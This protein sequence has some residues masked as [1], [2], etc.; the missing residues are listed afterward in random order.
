[1]FEAWDIRVW[2]KYEHVMPYN[3]F[4]PPPPPT[5]LCE[6]M[7]W[8]WT[9]AMYK[10]AWEKAD[11]EELKI[12]IFGRKNHFIT[13]DY[14]DKR[15]MRIVHR[16]QRRAVKQA[17]GLLDERHARLQGYTYRPI[18]RNTGTTETCLRWALDPPENESESE[19][20]SD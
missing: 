1:M 14:Y 10:Y 11:A 4:M 2:L 20:A 15:F 17:A 5:D 16:T 12:G 19:S 18:W 8:Q 3:F 13:T 9:Q 7:G 6:E